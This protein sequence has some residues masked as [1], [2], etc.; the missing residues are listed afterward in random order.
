RSILGDFFGYGYLRPRS[1]AHRSCIRARGLQS[2]RI[3]LC[4]TVPVLEIAPMRI[5]L[6]K[7][8]SGSALPLPRKLISAPAAMIFHSR[9]YLLLQ[10]KLSLAL[11]LLS[12][13]AHSFCRA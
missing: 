4:A 13:H 3:S 1:R 2:R 9:V 12:A 11:M 10:R 5:H 8:K 7:S 6:A